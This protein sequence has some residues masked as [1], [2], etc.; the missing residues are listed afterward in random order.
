MPRNNFDT[1]EAFAEK[2]VDMVLNHLK[3]IRQKRPNSDS[4]LLDDKNFMIDDL[5]TVGSLIS[6]NLINNKGMRCERLV[7]PEAFSIT[8]E[9][10]RKR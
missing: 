9:E 10:L 2:T 3:E 6:L 5:N 1:Q 8:I 7:A 4:I